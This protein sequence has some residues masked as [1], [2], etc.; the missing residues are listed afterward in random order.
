MSKFVKVF[1][2]FALVLALALVAFGQSEATS[3]RIT[4]VVKDSQGAAVPNASVTVSNS[5]TGFSQTI[6][7]NENGE[8]SAVQLKPG[9]YTIE[10]MAPGFGKATQTG[11]HVEVGSSLPAT[12]ALGVQTVNEEVLVTAASVDSTLPQTTT[13]INDT[14]ISQLPINGRRFQDFVLATPTAQIDPSRGQISLVGQRGI[15]GNV[16]ID[17]GDYNNPFFGGLRGGERSNQAFTI[18]QGAVREFQV[19]PAGFNAEFGRSTGGIVSVVT[20][21]GTNDYSGSAFFVVRPQ[22]YAHKNAF[23]QIAAPTQKQFGGAIGGPLYLP[24]FGEGGRSTTGGKD[25]SFF[26][27][28]YEE[29]RLNQT[30][31]V[32]FN[33]LHQVGVGTAG[34][35]EALNF[36]LGLEVPYGQ[37]NNAKVL[38]ARTDFNLDRTNQL[39]I[40]YNYS[41]NTALN[42]VT[43]GASLTPTTPNALSNN[44]TEGDNSNTI[45]GQWTSFLSPT[46]ISEFRAQYSKENRPRLAN[47]L[48]PLIQAGFGTFGTVSFLPTTESDYR[49]QLV[50]NLTLIRGNHNW[51]FG[52]EINYTKASQVFAQNQTG[53][54]SINGEAGGTVGSVNT[55]LQILSVGSAGGSDPANRFDTTSSRYLRQIGNGLLTLD[56]K[57]AAAFIQD[58]WR[59]RPNFTL[60]Y[61]LRYEYQILPQPDTSNAAVTNLVL[62]A[63]LPIGHVDPR[64]IDN[65]MKQFAPRLGFAWDPWK[66]GKGVIRGYSGIFYAR[67]PLLSLAGPLNNFR[68]PPG[69]LRVSLPFSGLPASGALNTVYK[70]FKSIGVDLNNFPL[71]N[72]PILTVAQFNQIIA[73]ISAAGG[74]APNP[75]SGLQ[76]ITV[77]R[78]LQNPRS[79]Q[80]GGGVEREIARGL[81][82]GANFDYV[83]TVHLNFNRD[84]DLPR[85]IIRTGDQSLRPF[86]GIATSGVFGAQNRPITAIG[87]GGYLQIRE[88]SARSLFRGLTFRGQL[89]RKFGQ[90]DAFYTLSKN[91]DSDSTERTASF[92]SYD[93]AYDLRNEYNFGALDRRH[94]V[95]V[96]T[97]LKAPF[98]FE[99]AANGRFASAAPLEVSV[100]GIVAPVDFVPSGVVSAADRNAAYAATVTVNTFRAGGCASNAAVQCSSTTTGDLNQDA[101]NFDDRPYTAPGISQKRN[102]YRNRPTKNIDLRVQRNFNFG[103]KYQLSPSVEFFNLFDFQNIQYAGT[104]VLNYGNPGVNERTGA[105]LAPSNVDFLQLRDTSGNLLNNNNAAAPFQVQFGLRF[106]F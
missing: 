22:K 90:F 36:A 72:L 93:N 18:P 53:T 3:G 94:I 74:T 91:L 10:V 103:E 56:S 71:N 19:V 42:A 100:S 76:L 54:F 62:N 67:F 60:S 104:R 99:I 86:F 75:L 25:K 61:G 66:D 27:V 9:D 83:N 50:N 41:T 82:V 14:S 101:G 65:Q 51:K 95:A 47:E 89:R 48:S 43:A 70:Q 87:N 37:T 78:G 28:A 98:G 46:T 68:T 49:V 32:L 11:Y 35:A 1:S 17:G 21:S 80:F 84:Y 64:I 58:S 88:S 69:D 24:R 23:S 105:V 20:K 40:R 81:T 44:G 16:Q 12:I 52:G 4:G 33:N 79:F 29:Q 92:A 8:F 59:L 30:R 55:I 6:M 26:F 15:N 106:K 97:V 5:A 96:S 102:S 2:V 34:T 77:G 7:T 31:A 39:S 85:P 38:L 45:V 73:N 57:E 63:N 13:N